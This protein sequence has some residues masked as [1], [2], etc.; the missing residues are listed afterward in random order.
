[1]V[2]VGP[3][4][5]CPFPSVGP[6]EYSRRRNACRLLISFTIEERRRSCH[7]SGYDQINHWHPFRKMGKNSTWNRAS[8]MLCGRGAFQVALIECLTPASRFDGWQSIA[9]YTRERTA[10]NRRLELNVILDYTSTP[11]NMYIRSV[12]NNSVAPP[13]ILFIAIIQ[14]LRP[15][16]PSRRAS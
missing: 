14:P 16:P 11:Y 8:K 2:R 6:R 9:K 3:G 15:G 4:W 10:N 1:M 7:A 12:H 5:D 13:T